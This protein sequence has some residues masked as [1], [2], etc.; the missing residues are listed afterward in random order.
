MKAKPLKSFP[1]R[2]SI[3][4]DNIIY[5]A[6]KLMSEAESPILIAGNGAIRKRSSRQLRE[7]CERTNIPVVTTFMGKGA[8]N[9]ESDYCLSTVG[10]GAIDFGDIAIKNSDLVITLG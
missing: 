1:Y 8:V 10:L 3:A 2:R 9:C 7:F 5:K 6:F 4:E